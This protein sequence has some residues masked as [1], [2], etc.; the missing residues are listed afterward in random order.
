MKKLRVVLLPL[1]VLAAV[2]VAPIPAS[3]DTVFKCSHKAT[4]CMPIVKCVV[5]E[6]RGDTVAQASVLLAAHDCSLGQVK[7]RPGR[8]VPVGTIIQSD[9]PA[10]TIHRDGKK[11]DVQVR[12]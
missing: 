12:R 1:A 4:Y 2:A 6:L 3:A 7:S 5:P 8:D 11:V 9:P 10:G